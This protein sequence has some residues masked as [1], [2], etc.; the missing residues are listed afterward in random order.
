M[1]KKVKKVDRI[2]RK[3]LFTCKKKSNKNRIPL[4]ITYNRTLPIIS[5]IVNGNLNIFQINI[6]FHRVFKAS[7]MISFKRSKNFQEII[8]GHTVKQTK[9]NGNSMPCTSTR[10][11]LCC[12]QAFMSQQTKRTFNISTK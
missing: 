9:L 5:K 10:Q 2:E 3:E 6:K 12:T 1:S 11:S 8:G 7:P 4:S